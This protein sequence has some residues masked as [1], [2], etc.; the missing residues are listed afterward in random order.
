LGAVETAFSVTVVMRP[1]RMFRRFS[2]LSVDFPADS[3][4]YSTIEEKSNAG[5]GQTQTLI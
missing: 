1:F 3:L 2:M 4:D 5:G